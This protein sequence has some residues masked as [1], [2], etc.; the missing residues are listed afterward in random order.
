M[1]NTT[2]GDENTSITLGGDGVYRWAYE[3]SLFK[4][5]TILFLLYK[6]FG[7][8]ALG[9]W[10]FVTLISA[11]DVGF[12][13]KGFLNNLKFFAIFTVG[14]LVLCTLG[15]LL[16]AAIMGGKYCVLFEMDEKGVRHTQMQ[17]QVKK[18]EVLSLI[19]VLVGLAAKNPT[20]VGTGLLSSSKTTMYTEFKKVRKIKPKRGASTIILNAAGGQNQ[21]Y[22]DKDEFDFVLEYITSR[23]P[24][25][26][27]NEKK[28]TK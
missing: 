27:A 1:K 6:I 25:K 15:Y 12:W 17:K 28:E 22:A 7:W 26:E 3:M 11:G 24:P 14:L 2:Q 8:I 13:W 4:N 23:V 5:P 21:V 10:V 16:Y 9:L 18:A 20:A 19:T